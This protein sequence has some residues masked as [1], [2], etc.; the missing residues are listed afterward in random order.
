MAAPVNLALGKPVTGS[1]FWGEAY[2]FAKVNDG[3]YGDEDISGD[4]SFWLLPNNQNGY[5]TIDLQ[6]L[7]MVKQFKVQDTHN[8]TYYDRG[9]NAFR[10]S[11]SVDDVNYVTVVTS[12]FTNDEW[13]NLTIKPYDITPT[14]ARYVRFDVDSFYIVG[15]GINELEVWGEPLPWWLPGALLLLDGD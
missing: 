5:V 15:G 8:R 14:P 12:S 4:T 11:L 1:A 2:P 10:I 3:R 9:T 13:T 6:K 7:F